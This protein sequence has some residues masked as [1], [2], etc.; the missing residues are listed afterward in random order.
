MRADLHIHTL[1]SGDSL[2][3]PALVLET[4]VHLGL[5]AVAIADHNTL[6]GSKEALGLDYDIIVLPAM[7]IT[8][9]EGHILAYNITEEI[10]RDLTPAR[11]IERIH[12]AGGIAVAPHPYRLWSGLGERVVREAPF[13]GLEALNG[14][15]LRGANSKARM[16]A[17]SLGLPMTCGSDA[18]SPEEIGKAHTV[19]PDEC[20][21]AEDL[22]EA[23]LQGKSDCAGLNRPYMQSFSYGRKAIGE[24]LKRGLRRI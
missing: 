11:T 22:V 12:D 13:D 20:S 8:S 1:H 15:S 17:N 9:S 10:E 5:G 6:R 4:A 3:T 21:A 24:W 19:F 18:H 7:E 16:L 2:Q 23:I 14:R